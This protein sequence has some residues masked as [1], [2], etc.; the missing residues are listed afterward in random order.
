MADLSDAFLEACTKHFGFLVEELGFKQEHTR[1]GSWDE[2]R[3]LSEKLVIE[4]TLEWRDHYLYVS[5]FPQT[6]FPFK[7]SFTRLPVKDFNRFGY[8]L[9]TLLLLRSSDTDCLGTTAGQRLTPEDIDKVIACYSDCLKKYGQDILQG[10]LKAFPEM[11]M[12]VKERERQ[13]K[14]EEQKKEWSFWD[15]FRH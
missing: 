13:R 4:C 7:T 14:S 8:N 9:D 11:E 3:F 2:V 5:L 15:I 6:E 12:L 10:D 1:P